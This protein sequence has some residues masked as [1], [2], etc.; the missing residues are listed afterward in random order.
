[1]PY[2]IKKRG[3]N[4]GLKKLVVFCYSFGDSSGG[5]IPCHYAFIPSF[6]LPSSAKYNC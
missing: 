5:I 3:K 2:P 6:F 4:K 1:M